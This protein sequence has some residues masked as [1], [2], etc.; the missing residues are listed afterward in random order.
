METFHGLPSPTE[1]FKTAFG[2][3]L[4]AIFTLPLRSQ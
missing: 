3:R 4:L 2:E 1:L